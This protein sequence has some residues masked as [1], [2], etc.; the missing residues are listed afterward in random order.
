VASVF[1]TDHEDFRESAHRFVGAEV[2]P[3]LPAWRASNELPRSAFRAA[4]ANG[5]LGTSAPERFGGEDAEDFGFLAV[6]IDETVDA[7]ATGLAVL[8]ALHAGVTIPALTEHADEQVREQWLP[9][10][11][12]GDSVGIP[13]PCRTVR[14]LPGAGLADLVLLD[15]GDDSITLLPTAT[16]GVS[17]IPVTKILAGGDAAPADLDT[18]HAQLSGHPQLPGA[19]AAVY[20]DVDLWLAVVA[21]A[22][23]RRGIGLAH[24]YVSTRRVF[25]RP[26]AEFENT[27]L[28]LAEL[29]A[30]LAT[31]TTYVHS[32]L[33]ARAAR[34]LTLAEAAAARL[35]S[36]ALSDRA[37]DQSLQLHGGYGY[38]RE[39]PVAQAFADARL[40]RAVGDVYSDPRRALAADLFSG[41]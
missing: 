30:E 23:A 13:A 40:L 15:G 7:G 14:G 35:V 32:C 26:L 27:R 1:G 9:D 6:L 11:I 4:G 29:W 25:G 21:V 10:L 3:H 8:W 5:F 41:P 16:H 24:E 28:R 2:L 17:R 31:V 34:T 19:A 36:V 38:M 12:A 33:S 18:S 37:L 22:G 20:R 39:Y